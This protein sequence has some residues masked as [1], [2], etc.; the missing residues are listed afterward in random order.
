MN[1]EQIRRELEDAQAH[2]E[3]GAITCVPIGKTYGALCIRCDLAAEWFE[4][5]LAVYNEAAS[6]NVAANIPRD[7]LP[8][9]TTRQ[10]AEKRDA[11]AERIFIAI[12]VGPTVVDDGVRAAE[13][14]FTLAEEFLKVKE[15]RGRCE[16]AT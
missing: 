5:K 6:Q 13:L 14:S 12:C 11:L 3:G 8:I 15:D 16:S 10:N 7:A 9:Y 4:K 1:K 2:D